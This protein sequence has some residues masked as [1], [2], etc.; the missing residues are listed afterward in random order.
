MGEAVIWEGV[1]V[2]NIVP[3]AGGAPLSKT[4]S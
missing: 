2:D 4:G 3:G 1:V